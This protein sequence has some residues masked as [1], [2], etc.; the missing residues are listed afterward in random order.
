[1]SARFQLLP[2]LT[3]D[4]RATLRD[5]IAEHGV[6]QPIV[7][8]ENGTVIDGHHRLAIAEELGVPCPR[9]VYPGYSEEQKRSLALR[10]NIH[11]RQLSRDQR[12]SLI[13]MLR[14]QGMTQQEIAK[15]TGVPQQTVSR[16]LN[17]HLGNDV[18]ETIVNARGQERPGRYDRRPQPGDDFTDD[19]GETRTVAEVEEHGDSLIVFDEDGDAV[20]V[21]QPAPEL[22]DEGSALPEWK[23]TKPDLGNG[24]SHPAR[25]S[26]ALV[27]EFRSIIDLY[28]IPGDNILDPFA[29]P[30]G[31][32]ELQNDGWETVGIEIEKEYADMHPSTVHG[33]ALDLPFDPETFAAIVTSPTYGNRLADSHNA[34]DPERRRSYTHDLGH[35][36]NRDNS[37]T[38]HWRTTPGRGAAGSEDYRNFHEKAWDEAVLVLRPGGL[39]VL[40][41][42]DHIRD[43][44]TQPVT[45]WHCWMLGRLGLEYVESRSVATQKLRQG[46]N[47]GLRH[48]EQVH[49]F[50]KPT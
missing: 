5:D 10:L 11:R 20:V 19:C 1:M 27:D 30:G 7:V 25:Y 16:V 44:L 14:S 35:P 42:C 23:P 48:Q 8:D 24:I 40:N 21:P 32:H 2:P 37:G 46:D 17:T 4:E 6:Q 15:E 18:P 31:I 12:N 29:G 45:A 49:V 38:M 43:G 13:A 34:S 26:R 22:D 50:R 47:A 9:S 3:E 39:F 41:C 33:S 28:G 36:L